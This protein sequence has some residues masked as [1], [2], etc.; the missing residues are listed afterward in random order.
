MEDLI[1]TKDDLVRMFES[2]EL[3]DDNYG[4]LLNGLHV[5]IVAIHESDPKYIHD[6]T[7]AQYYKI[8]Q[9]EK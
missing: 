8:I 4:W 9:K 5:E 6:V 7:N 2:K 1:I 3:Q